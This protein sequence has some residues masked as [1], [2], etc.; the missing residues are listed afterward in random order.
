MI[1]NENESVNLSIKLNNRTNQFQ[2]E[3]IAEKDKNVGLSNKGKTEFF[4]KSGHNLTLDDMDF[5]AK[6]IAANAVRPLEAFPSLNR[7][8]PTFLVF[9]SDVLEALTSKDVDE[10]TDLILLPLFEE[11]RG[12]WNLVVYEMGGS[13]FVFDSCGNDV[14][15]E[16]IRLVVSKLANAFSLKSV[17]VFL[18]PSPLHNHVSESG[19]FTIENIKYV[20][21]HCIVKRNKLSSVIERPFVLSPNFILKRRQ[22]LQYFVKERRNWNV[23]NP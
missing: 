3:L 6:E 20:I 8:H 19:I 16:Y 4:C 23:S 7:L 2:Q 11:S 9:R 15:L 14:N 12:T 17:N 22:E 13:F 10:E 1:D 18:K 21:E 5:L